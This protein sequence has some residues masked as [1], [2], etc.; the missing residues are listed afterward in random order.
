MTPPA[1][2]QWERR[3]RMPR[4][5]TRMAIAKALGVTSEFLEGGKQ[6]A[7]NA[8]HEEIDT[9]HKEMSLEEL[10]R[11]IEAKGFR[12]QLESRK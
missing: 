12:V 5:N 2:W 7:L 10:I 3:G 4:T 8:I 6:P 1:I 11:A 9:S